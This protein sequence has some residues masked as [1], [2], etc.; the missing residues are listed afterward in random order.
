MI[1]LVTLAWSRPENQ[2]PGATISPAYT[3]NHNLML[4]SAYTL[5]HLLH[6]LSSQGQQPPLPVSNP[7]HRPLAHLCKVPPWFL[8]LPCP[9]TFNGSLLPAGSNLSPV[10][11][12]LATALFAVSCPSVPRQPLQPDLLPQTI[13]SGPDLTPNSS[14]CRASLQHCPQFA[15]LQCPRNL[16]TDC[17]TRIPCTLPTLMP[18]PGNLRHVPLQPVYSVLGPNPGPLTCHVL[19]K[20]YPD[21]CI[22]SSKIFHYCLRGECMCHNVCGGQNTSYKSTPT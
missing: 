4:A 21:S 5:C 12:L 13:L 22:D 9:I 3:Q 10:A 16:L 7:V 14:V 8:S 19:G 18:S 20:L 17:D 6:D 2:A 11:Q 15:Q 1:K